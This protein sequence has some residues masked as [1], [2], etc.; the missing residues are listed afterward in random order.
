[1]FQQSPRLSSTVNGEVEEGINAAR[2]L[3]P[4]CWIDDV[5]CAKGLE[6]LMHYRRDYNQRLNEFKATPV[7]DWASHG[8]DAFRGLAVRH[9][10]PLEK[11]KALFVP[12]SQ[13]W[14]AS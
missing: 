7:H 8:A 13:S 5:N 6:A 14:M 11:K 1:V 3:L 4:K 9:Q 2:L 10:V 12:P